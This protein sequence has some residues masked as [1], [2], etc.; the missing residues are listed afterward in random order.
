MQ[1]N[2]NN[3]LQQTAD[4]SPVRQAVVQANRPSNGYSYG[5]SESGDGDDSDRQGLVEY[6]RI[7]QRYKGTI[8]IVAFLGLVIGLLVT[9]PQTPVYQA[10]LTLE[11]Q[12]INQN[13][14]NMKETA[15]VAESGNSA[16]ADIQTQLKIIL[17]D[18]LLERAVEKMKAPKPD[19]TKAT[20]SKV[21]SWRKTLNL[22]E[23]APLEARELAVGTARSNVKARAAG[24]TRIIEILSD[25]TDPLV[26]ADF[27]NT[28][29]NEYIEQNVEARWKMTQR[30]GDWLTRQLDDMRVKLERSEDALQ[31]YARQTGL[32]FTGEKQNISEEK[33][34]QLQ[35]SLSA[36]QADRI[37]KQSKWEMTKNASP[38]TLPDVLNDASLKSQQDKL[39]EL[40]RQEIDLSATYKGEYSKVKRVKAQIAEIERSLAQERKSITERIRNEYEETINREKLLAADYGNQAKLVNMDAEKSIEYNIL[41]R[42]VD[43]NRQLYDSMLQ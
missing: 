20:Q 36:S 42:E 17:S 14:L 5:Y 24:A 28:L 11:I 25:S 16:L 30:T 8:L 19:E 35:E 13:F 27:A 3:N 12:D 41:K 9:L 43:S 4:N 23:M 7:V 32:I 34:R 26:A 6:W 22:P 21:W 10:K 31:R 15:P 37:S 1:E 2:T 39:A 29:A 33:L 40:R 38:E 18:S